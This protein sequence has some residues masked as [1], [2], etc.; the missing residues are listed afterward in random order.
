MK[1]AICISGHLGQKAGRAALSDVARS[2]QFFFSALQIDTDYFL[3]LSYDEKT[4]AD[5]IDL[6]ENQWAAVQKKIYQDYNI[7]VSK[8]QYK[9][10]RPESHIER[11]FK[12]FEKIYECNRLKKEQEAS[13]GFKYDVVF[14]IRPDMIFLTDRV[15]DMRNIL[16]AGLGKNSVFIPEFPWLISRFT[17]VD[18]FAF[19]DSNS[20]DTYSETI[21]YIDEYCGKGLLFHPETLLGYHLYLNQ[22]DISRIIP[23]CFFSEKMLDMNGFDAPKSKRFTPYKILVIAKYL[24]NSYK[25]LVS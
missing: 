15:E 12:M 23:V 2:I 24:Y 9:Y 25:P 10:I 18:F 6:Y 16:T 20:M 1:A 22:S 4:D 19:G 21:H 7:D 8:K 3:V 14:R 13:E 5:I 11:T 17:Q